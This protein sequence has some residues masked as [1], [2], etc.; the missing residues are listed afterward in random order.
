MK[1]II[2]AVSE[3][4]YLK[5]EIFLKSEKEILVWHTECLENGKYGTTNEVCTLLFEIHARK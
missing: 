1:N 2:Y 3:Y 4:V 5:K